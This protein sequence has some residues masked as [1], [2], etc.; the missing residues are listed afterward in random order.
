MG[1]LKN[2]VGRPSNKTIII[3]RILKV[4]VLLIIIALAFLIGYNLKDKNSNNP[5]KSSGKKIQSDDS[6][7][8]SKEELQLD[9]SIV[10]KLYSEIENV[11]FYEKIDGNIEDLC[12]FY[13]EDMTYNDMDDNFKMSLVL[14]QF[15]LEKTNKI[16]YEEIK[17]KYYDIFGN[18]DIA[19][20][21]YNYNINKLGNVKLNKGYY[22]L[23]GEDVTVD[24]ILGTGYTLVSAQKDSSKIELFIAQWYNNADELIET[25]EPIYEYYDTNA[26]GDVKCSAVFK[27]SDVNDSKNVIKNKDKF[28]QYK[29][30]FIKKGK[31]YYFYSVEKVLY[32]Q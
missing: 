27:S 26:C 13:C 19:S 22:Q 12:A 6:I 20:E 3:R 4:V 17:E 11:S 1:V 5:I 32:I 18:Y 14:S 10:K 8:T 9:D 31:N 30:T 25:D 29:F 21:F 2:D 28:N 23:L 7:K 24:P 16:K 15:D